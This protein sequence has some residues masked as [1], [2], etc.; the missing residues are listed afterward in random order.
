MILLVEISLVL[1]VLREGYSD[2]DQPHETAKRTIGIR[3]AAD[4]VRRL[5]EA[6]SPAA[7]MRMPNQASQRG[8]RRKK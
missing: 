1:T 7:A 3:T 6:S 8:S 4:E 5:N 2:R